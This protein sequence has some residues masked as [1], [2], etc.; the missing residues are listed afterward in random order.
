MFLSIL[1]VVLCISITRTSTLVPYSSNGLYRVLR[2]TCSRRL[3]RAQCCP[4]S[5]GTVRT[6]SDG[7]PRTST[8]TFTH[9]LRSGRRL[10]QPTVK[11]GM[12]PSHWRPSGMV[13]VSLRPW[14]PSGRGLPGVA[15]RSRRP[16]GPG[17]L[18]VLSSF[19]LWSSGHSCF[20]FPSLSLPL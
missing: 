12:Q 4:T 19:R 15:F 18:P 17:V 2:P 10:T 11:I 9:L 13:L 6:V 5:T 20:R 7:E 16:T 8:S 1:V 14:S 3:V